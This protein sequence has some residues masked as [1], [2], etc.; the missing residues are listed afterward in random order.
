MLD[1][2]IQFSRNALALGQLSALRR[3]RLEAGGM[4][5]KQAHFEYLYENIIHGANNADSPCEPAGHRPPR[6]P[7]REAVTRHWLVEHSP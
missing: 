7:V 1:Q 2:R 5:I 4:I 6:P 3:Q